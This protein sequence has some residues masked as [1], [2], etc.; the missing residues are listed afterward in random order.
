MIMCTIAN[1]KV[2]YD[3]DVILL[4]EESK[5]QLILSMPLKFEHEFNKILRSII[6]NKLWGENMLGKNIKIHLA[7]KLTDWANS[8]DNPEI[9]EII[10]TKTIISGGSIV[11]L[12][13]DEE[14]KDYDVYIEDLESLLKI[15]NYYLDKYKN[16][17]KKLDDNDENSKLKEFV[18]D[19][20]S[21]CIQTCY[22]NDD[23]ACWSVIK[24]NDCSK[25]DDIRL[26]C[27]IRSYGAA[28]E[29]VEASLFSLNKIKSNNKDKYYPKLFTNN[30]ITLSD[31]IQLVLRFYGNADKIRSSFDFV[32]TLCYYDNSENKLELPSRSLEAIINKE[33]YYIGSKY[34][35]CSIIRT[36]KFLKK[37]YTIDASQYLKMVLQ[38]N[39]MDLTNIH[40]LEEQLIGVDSAYF[41]SVINKIKKDMK[42]DEKIDINY[43][44]KLITEVFDK[45]SVDTSDE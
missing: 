35:L 31:K 4:Y 45:E 27:F 17:C 9:S 42:I 6:C 7:K 14:P 2:V 19:N 12:L 8:V 10:L 33:L 32:H 41:S 40:V 15:S 37:G 5:N 11:S 34:P 21:F 39:E 16:S 28:G 1:L 23:K 24:H 25:Y 43:L 29:D 18:D 36:R 3:E 13:N 20:K 22:W 44:I 26:R 30:A 38:L